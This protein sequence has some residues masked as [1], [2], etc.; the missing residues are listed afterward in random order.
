MRYGQQREVRLFIGGDAQQ[1][2]AGGDGRQMV[3]RTL[4]PIL[5]QTDQKE[6]DLA[7]AH[8]PGL[9]GVIESQGLV[10]APALNLA[11]GGQARRPGIGVKFDGHLSDFRGDG[12][13]GEAKRQ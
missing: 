5:R 8:Q 12:S 10:A 2:A 6:F 3:A 11:L 1:Q 13:G 4:G 7:L 9:R